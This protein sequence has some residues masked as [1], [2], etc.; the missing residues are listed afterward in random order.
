MGEMPLA[1]L[2]TDEGSAGKGGQ[3][4]P[5]GVLGKDPLSLRGERRRAVGVRPLPGLGSRLLHGGLVVGCGQVP[6]GERPQTDRI[7]L[8]S[9]WAPSSRAPLGELP[10]PPHRSPS[11][12]QTAGLRAGSPSLP[13]CPGSAPA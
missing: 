12:P 10:E 5:V 6:H 11:A 1:L 8:F 2:V 9:T 3:T 4:P 7:T 13:T